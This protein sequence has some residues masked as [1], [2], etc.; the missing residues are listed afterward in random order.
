[1]PDYASLPAIV[2]PCDRLGRSR[3]QSGKDARRLDDLNRSNKAGP[4]DG[5]F[6][7][8]ISIS[9]S[10]EVS[11]V[12]LLQIYLDAGCLAPRA[13]TV[14][15]IIHIVLFKLR[16]S[17]AEDAFAQAKQAIGALKQVPGAEI[18]GVWSL[19]Y[20]TPASFELKKG[21]FRCISARL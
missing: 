4:K 14:P 18:V 7:P 6:L 17:S 16:R 5:R 15:E 19:H 13:L 8:Y 1:M 2:P 21:F 12:T 3:T 11:I 20:L 9:I 10:W